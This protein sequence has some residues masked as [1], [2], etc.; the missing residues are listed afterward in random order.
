MRSAYHDSRGFTSLQR[1]DLFLFR[2]HLHRVI[3]IIG[4]AKTASTLHLD[5]RCPFSTLSFLHAPWH[6]GSGPADQ[7][8]TQSNPVLEIDADKDS[9]TVRVRREYGIQNDRRE[10]IIMGTRAQRL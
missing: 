9:V 7:L 10:S 2:H 3:N 4:N 8:P 1:L 5:E 6:G